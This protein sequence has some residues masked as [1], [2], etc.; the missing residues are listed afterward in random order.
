[1]AAAM[2]QPESHEFHELAS[3]TPSTVWPSRWRRWIRGEALIFETLDAHGGRVRTH[4]DALSLVLPH[5]SG[6]P[7]PGRS[8]C[9]A[10][11]RAI[12]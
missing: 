10:R 5:D 12:R 1:M 4:A 8:S 11:S 7:R 2:K 6:T 9:V 3:P